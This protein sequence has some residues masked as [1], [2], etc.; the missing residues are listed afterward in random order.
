MNILAI[1]NLRSGLGDPGLDEL[2]RELGGLGAELT[3]RFLSE[4][5]ALKHLLRDASEY[6]RV[7]AIGGD[8]T[9]S[10]VLYELRNTGIP[11]AVYPAGTANLFARN[12]G[13]PPDP[14]G[15]AA[16]ALNGTPTR[17]DLGELDIDGGTGFFV[18]AGA[19]F[20]AAL[21]D[22][23]RELKPVIGEGAYILAAVQNLQPTVATFLLTLDGRQ[24]ATEGIAVLLVN[25]ARLQFDLDVIHGSDAQDGLLEVVILKPTSVAGLLPAVWAALLD[26]IGSHA[27]RPGL[28]VHTA[29]EIE[30]VTAPPLCLQY[31]G[32]VLPATTPFRAR[33]LPGAAMV[34]MPRGGLP[35][36]VYAS[37]GG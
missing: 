8:G 37:A 26:R 10:A 18:M 35:R 28:E 27:A 7:L 11:V 15:L 21:I 12:L 17:L 30:V 34:V 36:D 13:L 4:R 22:G 16:L 2:A 14:A 25:L 23:A 5:S 29:R 31:D 9:I 33:V 3:V 19:G 20:D 24:I 1:A 32:E 6:D